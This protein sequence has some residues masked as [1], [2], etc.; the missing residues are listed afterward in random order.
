MELGTLE[1]LEGRK[2]AFSY[3]LSLLRSQPDEACG[4]LPAIDIAGMEHLAWSLDALHYLLEVW[5]WDWGMRVCVCVCVI[6]MYTVFFLQTTRPFSVAMESTEAPPPSSLTDLH[7]ARFFH[8]SNS[9][10]CLGAIPA[11]PFEPLH[12]SLPLAEK[13]HLLDSTYNKQQLFGFEQVLV[14]ETWPSCDLPAPPILHLI[15]TPLPRG[16]RSGGKLVLA[17]QK[18][19]GKQG[20]RRYSS[21]CSRQPTLPVLKFC[22]CVM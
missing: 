22:V 17:S 13:P 16:Q 9:T 5:N 7:T 20:R 12:E 15:S 3:L 21:S 8:R 4:V 19:D 6:Y 11:S 2:E 1:A 10:V 18:T 14:L